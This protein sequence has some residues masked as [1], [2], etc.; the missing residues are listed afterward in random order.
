MVG[1]SPGSAIAGGGFGFSGTDFNN[2][3]ITNALTEGVASPLGIASPF[4]AATAKANI[5]T[6]Y[7]DAAL[8]VAGVVNIITLDIGGETYTPGLYKTTGALEVKS[9]NLKLHGRGV[10]I[11]QIEE[12]FKVSEI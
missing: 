9:G 1:V 7:L 2:N 5:G 4:D 6:A 3:D 12:T 8:R 10:Y 11:F